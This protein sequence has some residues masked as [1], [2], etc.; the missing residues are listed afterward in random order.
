LLDA[1]VGVIVTLNPVAST[2]DDEFV[3]VPLLL[4]AVTT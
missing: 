2:N 3:E 4:L 1:K